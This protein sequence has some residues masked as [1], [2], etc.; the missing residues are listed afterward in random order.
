MGGIQHVMVGL[1]CAGCGGQ[2]VAVKV[3][4]VDPNG[5]AHYTCVPNEGHGYDCSSRYT[6]HQY[7]R[8]VTVSKDHC[9]YGVS[10]VYV[11]TDWRGAVTR[12][13]YTCGTPPSGDFPTESEGKPCLP[14]T[15]R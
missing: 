12:I 10:R 1:L 4:E 14:S 8:E 15:P 6:F 11:E 2:V 13:Q 3:A 7:D 5:S 9:A